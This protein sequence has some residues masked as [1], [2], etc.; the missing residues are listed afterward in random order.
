MDKPT[1]S[2]RI[3]KPRKHGMTN[4]KL[5]GVWSTM[6]SRCENY[7]RTKYNSYGGRGI[8]VCDEWHDS[9]V[10]LEWALLNGYQPGLQIDRIDNNKGY[11]PGNCRFVTPTENS[12]NRRNT[13]LLTINNETKCVAEVC[14]N[15]SVSQFTIYWW[16]RTRG[17]EYTE[18]RIREVIAYG[19]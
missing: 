9:C 5:Y 3:C 17:R 18:K 19:K 11:C 1:K 12:R 10:F 13:K 4:T 15:I 8:T 14:E 16:L 6:I 2:K 7:N